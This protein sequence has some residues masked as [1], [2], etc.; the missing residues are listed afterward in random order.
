MQA[1]KMEPNNPLPEF[2]Y[3]DEEKSQEMLIDFKGE[4]S[5]WVLVDKKKWFLPAKYV[6]QCPIYYNFNVEPDDTWIFTFPR[7]GN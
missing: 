5:G 4:K 3:L 1:T 7:S 6:K 2:E